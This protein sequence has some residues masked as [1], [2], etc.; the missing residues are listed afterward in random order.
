MH[1]HIHHVSACTHAQ[2][3]NLMTQK[4]MEGGLTAVM[5]TE[6]VAV[7]RMQKESISAQV[8]ITDVKLT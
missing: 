7:A 2:F 4:E 6:N 1:T 3:C 5:N 8:N